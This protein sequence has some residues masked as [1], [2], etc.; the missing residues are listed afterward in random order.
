MP[1]ILI[2]NFCNTKFFNTKK[3]NGFPKTDPADPAASLETSCTLSE[4]ASP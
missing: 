2:L 4:L 1:S 3:S